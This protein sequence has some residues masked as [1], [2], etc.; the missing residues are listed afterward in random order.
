M[1]LSLLLFFTISNW[2]WKQISV[3]AIQSTEYFGAVEW[4][5]YDLSAECSSIYD[6]AIYNCDEYLPYIATS[7][8][9]KYNT[10][11]WNMWESRRN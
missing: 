3:A 1:N 4:C 9:A 6:A 5:K 8:I 11:R 10:R 7:T 2:E